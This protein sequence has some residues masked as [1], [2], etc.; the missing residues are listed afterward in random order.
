MALGLRFLIG[1]RAIDFDRHAVERLVKLAKELEMLF[2]IPGFQVDFGFHGALRP[3]SINRD[4][5]SRI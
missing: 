3:S 2:A 4:W 1:P 5:E